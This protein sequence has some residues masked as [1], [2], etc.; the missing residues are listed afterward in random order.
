VD[1]ARQI[2]A[3]L[4]MAS[5]AALPR[6]RQTRG[7]L[8]AIGATTAW[9]CAGLF[10]RLVETGTSWHII[11]YRSLGL[12]AAL[13]AMIAAI[14]RRQ[15][16]RAVRLAGG[17][18]AL[19]GVCSCASSAFFILA[20]GQVTV[21][22]ALFMT[23]IAPFLA[24][25][26]G[27]L[28]LGERVS[29]HTWGAMILAAAGVAVMLG[30][31]LAFGRL[32]GNLLA[33]ASATSFAV[34]GVLVRQNRQTDMLPAVLYSG[35]YGS[36]LG[37]VV[38]LA[39]GGPAPPLDRIALPPRD[40]ALCVGMGVL[41]LALGMALYTRASRHLP[42]AELQLLATTELILAPLWVWIGVGEVPTVATV[43]GGALI[44]LAV[45]GQGFAAWREL[46]VPH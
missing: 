20:L 43:V 4:T 3:R 27:R 9:S 23:G 7:R 39:T 24:A 12:T 36:V 30:Q 26:G 13:A 5:L 25:L 33:L 41:Q 28:V 42:A 45:L 11:L 32:A 35:L 2:P 21:A 29:R 22:N 19:A 46:L 1:F 17:T 34:Y 18:A 8:L 16:A 10:V 31:G 14:H 15:T 40:L 6:A 44:F 38:R 37:L